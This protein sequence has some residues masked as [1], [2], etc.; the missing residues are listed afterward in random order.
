MMPVVF[1]LILWQVASLVYPMTWG[2]FVIARFDWSNAMIGASL[3]AVGIVIALSQT[4]LTGPA[5]RRF[6]ERDA[7]S[8]GLIG[9]IS[10]FVAYV[11]ATESWMA[12][13]IMAT[14]AIQSLVQPSLMSILSRSA[15]ADT[16]GEVQGISS[17][18][19][20]IGAMVAPLM[21]TQPLAYFTSE[22]APFRFTGAAFTIAAL[23]ASIALLLVRQLPRQAPE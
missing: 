15:T 20:G 8:I 16:Q 17:M 11:W 7:A 19:M 1:I 5:V 4:F 3:A 6:G 2:F 18:A 13:A 9:A 21:L 12:F 14:L 23:I 10:G 22:Q